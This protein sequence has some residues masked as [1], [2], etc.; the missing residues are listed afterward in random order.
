MGATS[1][2]RKPEVEKDTYFQVH[3]NPKW[4]EARCTY[5]TAPNA[6]HRLEWQSEIEGESYRTCAVINEDGVFCTGLCYSRF[7]ARIKPL[8]GDPMLVAAAMR[9]AK[10]EFDRET[11][12]YNDT[13]TAIG[14][15]ELAFKDVS[16][17]EV[18]HMNAVNLDIAER[19]RALIEPTPGV[20]I[21]PLLAGLDGDEWVELDTAKALNMNIPREV[22]AAKRDEL[23]D[24]SPVCAQCEEM[25]FDAAECVALF[26]N[27]TG[28][29]ELVHATACAIE[30]AIAENQKLQAAA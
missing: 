23:F 9:H 14:F 26:V 7:I 2:K 24:E 18:R 22:L 13:G 21:T 6:I 3:D 17:A 27:R 19:A 4:P 20:T 29:F 12:P 28:R 15:G 10:L 1:L 30:L 11:Y 5:C 8:M 25:V 16:E